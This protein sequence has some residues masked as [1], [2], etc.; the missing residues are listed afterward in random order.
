[1]FTPSIVPLPRFFALELPAFTGILAEP[2]HFSLLE[3]L[4]LAAVILASALLFWKRFGVVLNKILH[5]RKDPSFHFAPVGKRIWEFFW[6]VLC[7]A[8]V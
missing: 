5:S 1:M 6:A 4:L 8:K 3:K 2:P 7:Q